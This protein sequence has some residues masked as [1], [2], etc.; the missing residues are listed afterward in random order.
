MHDG[1]PYD[2]IQ[3]QGQGQGHDCLKATRESKAA[4]CVEVWQTSNL[5]PLR[6]VEERK[7]KKTNKRQDENIYALLHRAAINNITNVRIVYLSLISKIIESVVKSR[8]TDHLTSNELLISH[9]RELRE[10][11]RAVHAA[12]IPFTLT[13]VNSKAGNCLCVIFVAVFAF[14]PIQSTVC[15]SCTYLQNKWPD[16]L[17]LSPKNRQ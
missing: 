13:Q 1:V 6:L 4:P 16:C 14:W 11:T 15:A 2:P 12:S 10:L 5:R 3:G 17:Y 7:K 9:W 8:R